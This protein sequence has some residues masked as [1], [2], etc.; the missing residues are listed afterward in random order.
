MNV[1]V[2]TCPVAGSLRFVNDERN[3]P[4]TQTCWNA[5]PPPCASPVLRKSSTLVKVK[6]VW[7]LTK[8]TVLVPASTAAAKS[9]GRMPSPAGCTVLMARVVRGGRA[10][11]VIVA[12][13]TF[14]RLPA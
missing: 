14:S 3:T 4:S 11:T 1:L 9:C 13:C 6:V 10:S 2:N 5:A 12:M 8:A 7:L